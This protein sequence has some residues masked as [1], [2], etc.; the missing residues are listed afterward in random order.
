MEKVDVRW[1]ITDKNITVSY[2]GEMHIVAKTDP[3]ANDLIAALKENRVNEIPDLVSNA[4]KIE[5]Y[6]KGDFTVKDGLVY[7]NGNKVSDYLSRK[8]LEFIDQKLPHKPLVKFAEKL[9]QNPSFRAVNELYC[10]LEKNNHPLTEEGNFIAYK[11]VRD[12]FKDV[13]S[14]K[15]DNSPGKVLEMPRNEVNENPNETCSYGLHVANWEYAANF[16]SGGVMLEIEV[17]PADVVAIPVDYNQSKMRVCKYKVLQVVSQPHNENDVLKVTSPDYNSGEEYY[18]DEEDDYDDEEDEYNH[19]N[20][21]KC[22]QC[23]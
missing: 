13:H 17:N 15:F 5:N 10:F 18:D 14:G 11:K 9:S 23:E 12:D 20:C 4:K 1:L 21:C 16:Y 22:N 6:G 2:N 8:I 3:L 19:Y 7:V